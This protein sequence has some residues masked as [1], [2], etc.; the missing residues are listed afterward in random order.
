MPSNSPNP[1]LLDQIVSHLAGEL[2]NEASTEIRRLLESDLRYGDLA[3]RLGRAI[4]FLREEPHVAPSSRARERAHALL[5]AARPGLADRLADG[6]RRVVAAL[7]FDTRQT[8]AMAGLRGGAGVAQ[9]AFS[10]DEAD[11]DLELAE[12][13][14]DRW[15]LRGTVDADDDGGWSIELRDDTGSV[16]DAGTTDGGSFA[17]TIAAGSYTLLASRGG[18]VIEAGPVLVP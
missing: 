15:T 2:P 18:T 10:A 11:I 8:P 1:D 14:P 12:A 16:I 7:D 9:V 3:V 4:S 13:G 5:A 17:V 6:V